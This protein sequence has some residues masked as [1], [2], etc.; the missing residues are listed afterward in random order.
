M[1]DHRRQYRSTAGSGFSLIELLVTLVIVGC[2]ASIALPA[3]QQHLVKARR[4]AAQAQMMDLANREQ[5]YLIANR[6]YA[7]RGEL[8]AA[9]YALPSDLARTYDWNVALQAAPPGFSIVFSPIAGG[10]QVSDGPLTL[11]HLGTT[12][13]A[14][15]W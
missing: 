1:A 3:Y 11:D 2:L 10:A 6:G 15:K 14:G 4:L 9:G 5:Q 7:S 8:E 12:G 13:P